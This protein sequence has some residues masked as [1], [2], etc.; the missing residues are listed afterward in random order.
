MSSASKESRLLHEL[1]QEINMND[2]PAMSAHVQELIFLTNS[3]QATAKELTDA[4]LKD[5]SLTNKILQVSNSAYYSR[6]VPINNVARAVTTIGFSVVRQLAMAIALF[7][8]LVKISALKDQ[9]LKILTR[10]FLSATQARIHSTQNNISVKPD[11]AFL[12]SLLHNLGE[13]VVLVYMP[14]LYHKILKKIQKGAPLKTATREVLHTLTFKKIGQ[15][16]VLSW[17]FSKQIHDT[18]IEVPPKSQSVYDGDANLK[19]LVK[20]TL[21]DSQET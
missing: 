13:V 16:I 4:I 21:N 8:E 1:L 18:M 11:D 5:Y 12:C 14:S 17:N 7:E 19:N 2:L 6:G 15:K 20:K 10:S 3:S 9:L